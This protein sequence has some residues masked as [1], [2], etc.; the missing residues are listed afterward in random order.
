MER[1]RQRKRRI[2]A[3]VLSLNTQV[4]WAT[5]CQT[6]RDGAFEVLCTTKLKRVVRQTIVL[7]KVH[8]HSEN[9]FWSLDLFHD[10]DFVIMINM[11]EFD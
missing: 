1:K 9:V 10:V 7:R 4:A 8:V 6:S 11:D 3:S 2:I 5:S